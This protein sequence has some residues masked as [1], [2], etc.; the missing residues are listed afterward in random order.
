MR[1]WIDCFFIET[2]DEIEARLLAASN[3]QFQS[4]QRGRLEDADRPSLSA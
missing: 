3:D 1:P 4:F 2:P